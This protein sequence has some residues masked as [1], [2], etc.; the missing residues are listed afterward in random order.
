MNFSEALNA[1]KAGM[2]IQRK[3]WSGKG[4]YVRLVDLYADDA[5][6]I[7]EQEPIDGTLLP[8]LALKTADNGFVP[9]L[10]PQIDILADDWQVV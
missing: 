8:F 5:F 4:M 1:A 6:L 10:A 9:W 3:G 7:A 2:K